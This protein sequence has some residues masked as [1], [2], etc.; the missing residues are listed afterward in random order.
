MK[1][2]D[3]TMEVAIIA[4]SNNGRS[5]N[6][7]FKT[8]DEVVKDFSPRDYSIVAAAVKDG[9]EAAIKNHER[10]FLEVVNEKL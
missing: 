10:E 3:K 6:R 7:H 9:V 5:I 1:V 8:V 4:F 2:S